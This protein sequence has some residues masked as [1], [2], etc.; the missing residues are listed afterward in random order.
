M[1]KQKKFW[2]V[3]SGFLLLTLGVAVF[4]VWRGYSEWRHREAIKN[5]EPKPDEI[6]ITKLPN[7]DQ[8]VENKTQLYKFEISGNLTVQ[9]PKNPN[10]KGVNILTSNEIGCSIYFN[11]IGNNDH[12]SPVEYFKK[13]YGDL[14]DS[15]SIST[16]TLKNIVVTIIKINSDGENGYSETIYIPAE[17]FLYSVVGYSGKPLTLACKNYLTSLVRSA[18][19]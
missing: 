9:E 5:L 6:V 12:L 11:K 17:G 16:S 15:Y 2:A 19:F 14:V 13:A 18:K 10:D 1:I 3:I 7:G 4:I 8:L